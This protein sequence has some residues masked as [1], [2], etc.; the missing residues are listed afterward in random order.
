[1]RLIDGELLADLILGKIYKHGQESGN[2]DDYLEIGALTH[3]DIAYLDGYDK[4]LDDVY[5]QISDMKTVKAIPVE[6]LE[7]MWERDKDGYVDEYGQYH[8]YESSLGESCRQVLE[9]WN[10]NYKW[11]WE[12]ENE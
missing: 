1:M 3:N 6:W 7:Q 2:Y 12:K 11:K 9:N 10:T 5:R 4:A 8:D